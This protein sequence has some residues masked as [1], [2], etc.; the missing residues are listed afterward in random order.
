MNFKSKGNTFEDVL[1]AIIMAESCIGFDDT[2]CAPDSSNILIIC[3]FA[4]YSTASSKLV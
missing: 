3:G 1:A 4:S 2:G